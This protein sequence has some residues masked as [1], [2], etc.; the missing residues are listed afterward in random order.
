MADGG[1]DPCECIFNHE[2]AMRRL[3]SLLRCGTGTGSFVLSKSDIWSPAYQ[4][5][6]AVTERAG[7]FLWTACHFNKTVLF[8]KIWFFK[9]FSFYFLY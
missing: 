4:S 2:M 1:F 7:K 3:L 5:L 9:T 6:L 8:S